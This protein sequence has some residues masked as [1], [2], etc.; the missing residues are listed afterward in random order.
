MSETLNYFNVLEKLP[1]LLG[2][3]CTYDLISKQTVHSSRGKLVALEKMTIWANF[4][5]L[6]GW[7]W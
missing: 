5:N 2:R 7:V 6:V 4:L 3:H 1:H